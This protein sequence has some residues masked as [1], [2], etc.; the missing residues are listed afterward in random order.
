MK[1]VHI[2]LFGIGN[3]GKT[4]IQQILDS[5]Y[6]FKKQHQ[7]DLRI[8]GLANS[9]SVLTHADGIG[10]DWK[11]AFGKDSILR[12]PDSF[13]TFSRAQ[14]AIKIAVDATASAELS[15]FYPEIV[16]HGFHIVTANKIANTLSQDYYDQLR[17]LLKEKNLLQ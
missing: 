5:Q 6:F 12:E 2:Y 11:E 13:Y 8:V 1:Q 9:R 3:V 7:L 17:D 16:T 14:Q 4:F 15:R 10:T